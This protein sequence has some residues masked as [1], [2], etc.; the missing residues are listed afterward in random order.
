[1]T[2]IINNNNF[3]SEMNNLTILEE[4][5]P[6][7][8]KL[9]HYSGETRNMYWKVKDRKT[10]EIYYIMTIMGENKEELFTKISLEDIDKVLNFKDIRPC[11]FLIH[12]GYVS[13][14]IKRKHTYLHQLIMD[15]HDKDLSDMKETVDHINNDKLD[16]RKE[17]LRLVDMS[18]QNA[19]RPKSERRK[20]ACDLPDGIEQKD[21]PKYVSYRKE[22]LDKETGKFREFFIIAP[23]QG[24]HPKLESPWETTKSSKVDIHKKLELAKL[25]LQELEGK[26]SS[27]EYN[28]EQDL[29]GLDKK[30]DLPVG[31]RLIESNDKLQFNYD[32]RDT[33][34]NLRYNSKM[35]LKSNDL[36]KELDNFIDIIN[37]KYDDLKL[38]K[39]V[40]K[41]INKVDDTKIS[42]KVVKEKEY[43]LPPNF[44]Y[45]FDNKSNGY[46]FEFSKYIDKKR[47]SLKMKVKNDD[48]QNEFNNFIDKLNLK[49]DNLNIGYSQIIL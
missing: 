37:K 22:I 16:N 35:V 38:N 47:Y 17:N 19:N 6:L 32:Y 21:L 9:G 11:W 1:M 26:I 29:Q 20:D 18:I 48:I 24:C 49:Y 15:V 41:N 36:Q 3:T 45:Y 2:N 43:N 8:I 10:K 44:S 39:Y 27:E 14:T 31:I 42:N 7:T 33:K 12:N 5:T 28:K 4:G 46:I 13:T 23:F 34:N 40:I 25:K 30:V